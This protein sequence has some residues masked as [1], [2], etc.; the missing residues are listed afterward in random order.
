MHYSAEKGSFVNLPLLLLS[1]LLAACVTPLAAGIR[2]AATYRSAFAEEVRNHGID[3]LI[4]LLSSKN[5]GA[6]KPVSVK[7]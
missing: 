6:L 4:S 1:A 5:R 2:L 3:G 7:I